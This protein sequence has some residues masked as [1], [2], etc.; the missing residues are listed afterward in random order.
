MPKILILNYQF[1]V[2]NALN[3]EQ[4]LRV[5]QQCPWKPK[6]I[7]VSNQEDKSQELLQLGIQAYI[8]KDSCIFSNLS[9]ALK[10]SFLG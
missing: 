8:A 4:V 9:A 7:F 10:A 5:L 1:G 2:D 3:G 6:I